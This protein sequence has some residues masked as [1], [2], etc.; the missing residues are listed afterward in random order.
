MPAGAFT[1]HRDRV[2]PVTLDPFEMRNDAREPLEVPPVRVELVTWR[3]DCDALVDS[4]T[5]IAGDCA[6]R[7]AVGPQ[8]GEQH[9]ATAE[10]SIQQAA[11]QAGQSLAAQRTTAQSSGEAKHRQRA[12]E[13]H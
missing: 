3:I 2:P 1:V 6:I 9:A 5:E 7:R 12:T 13:E 10:P 4:D 8:R 11:A